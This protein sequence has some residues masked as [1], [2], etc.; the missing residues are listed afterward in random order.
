MRWRAAGLAAVLLLLLV[1]GLVWRWGRPAALAAALAAPSSEP[2]LGAF[3]DEPRREEI[4]IPSGD[5]RLLA[6]VYRPRHVRGTLLLVHGLSRAGRRQPDLERLARLVAGRGLLV[7]VPQFDGLAAFKLTGR[8]VDDIR[9]ALLHAAAFGP[10]AQG[11]PARTSLGVAGFSF[12]AGPALI[13]AAGVPDLRVAASFGSYADLVH[14]ITYVTTGAHT[15]DGRRYVQRQEEYNR[16][17]LLA[18]LTPLVAAP[19]QRGLLDAIAQRKLAYPGDD[20]IALE[21]DLAPESRA[22]LALAV[23]RREDQVAA[24]VAALPAGSRE[25]LDRMSPL[26][27]VPRLR[28]RLLLAHG[29]ADDSIPFTESLRLAAAAGDRAHLALFETFHHTGAQPFWSSAMTRMA[30]AGRL[31]RVVDELL[32]P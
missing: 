26:A 15:F 28:A 2:W 19:D 10:H 8:E 9:A 29:M 20:T 30:D 27:V 7:V 13:A 23:N 25:A 21:R 1:G 12:G 6:D 22:I 11:S 24:L 31:L 4:E 32:G 5:G 16:W 14:V 3:I 17:K 18:L